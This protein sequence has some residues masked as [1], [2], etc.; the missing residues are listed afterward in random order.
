[1]SESGK[2]FWLDW[3]VWTWVSRTGHSVQT[4]LPEGMAQHLAN[5]SE[6][7]RCEFLD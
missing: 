7:G 1:L 6:F 3:Q 2:Q 4:P 5:G